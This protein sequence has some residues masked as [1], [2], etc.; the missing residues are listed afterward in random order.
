MK[1]NLEKVLLRKMLARNKTV[2]YK[3]TKI[4]VTNTKRGDLDVT[5]G[6]DDIDI[7][8]SVIERQLVLWGDLFRTGK[9]LRVNITFNYVETGQSLAASSR[10]ADK[11]R[12]TT[13]QMLTE[14]TAQLD[15]EGGLSGHPSIWNTVY[16]LMR[17]PGPPCHLGPHC[18]RDPVSKKHYKLRTKHLKSLMRHVEQG[19]ELKTHA[20]VP[21]EV[22]EQLYT[23]EQ[24]GLERRQTAASKS[25]AT[26]PPINITNVLPGQPYHTPHICPSRNTGS[27]YAFN[28][29]QS[30]RYPWPSRCSSRG[31]QSLAAVASQ[32]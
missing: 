32:M 1:L 20:D 25:A 23:E 3:D 9:K 26:F 28:P 22:R 12:S 17:C 30:S 2:K 31:V 11:R 16:S 15:E 27:R 18:W 8:W 14:R 7:D 24:Q 13:Q 5:K 6:F 29:S 21:E 19:Y 10:K 4:V